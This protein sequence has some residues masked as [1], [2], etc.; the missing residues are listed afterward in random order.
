MKKIK[1]LIVIITVIILYVAYF[2]AN[3]MY[4]RHIANTAY[5]RMVIMD[6]ELTHLQ[7]ET[8]ELHHEKDI[9]TAIIQEFNTLNNTN[10]NDKKSTFNNLIIQATYE[11]DVESSL[12][13]IVSATNNANFKKNRNSIKVQLR[14]LK[15]NYNKKVTEFNSKIDNM[16]DEVKDLTVQVGKISSDNLQHLELAR[17]K[18]ISHKIAQTV[19]DLNGSL[20]D[21]I[22]DEV[23]EKDHISDKSDN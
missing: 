10:F 6:K 18:F 8:N 22:I 17:L 12:L 23:V 20:V 19:V 14:M 5:D 1:P 3:R 9:N 21:K 2:Y 11:S 7:Q 4:D 15:Y 13:T 16:T